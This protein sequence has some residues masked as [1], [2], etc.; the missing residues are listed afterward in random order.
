[1][2]LSDLV[3]THT[4]AH[5]P[6]LQRCVCC[7]CLAALLIWAGGGFGVELVLRRMLSAGVAASP[8]LARAPAMNTGV[9]G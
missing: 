2:E 7:G 4:H 3:R 9:S 5:S 6:T 1:M 8:I